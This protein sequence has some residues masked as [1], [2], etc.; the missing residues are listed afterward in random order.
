MPTPPPRWR[1]TAP[2]SQP[3]PR[4]P[5]SPRRAG[6]YPTPMAT[7]D[8]AALSNSLARAMLSRFPLIDG[9]NDLPWE[10]R[11]ACD[12]DLA[13]ASI[14]ARLPQSHTDI[15]RLVEGGVGGQWWSVYVPG[16]LSGDEAVRVTLEQVDIVHQMIARYPERFSL[17]LTADDVEAAFA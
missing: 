15:P 1:A 12:S 4:C 2:A 10:I 16:T 8:G 13:K 11:V 3:P 7:A 9:H 17:A 6:A 5:R 14:D